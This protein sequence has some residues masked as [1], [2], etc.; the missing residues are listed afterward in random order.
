MQDKTCET[1]LSLNMRV[2]YA[3]SFHLS[4]SQMDKLKEFGAYDM[5]FVSRCKSFGYIREIVLVP[6]LKEQKG[7]DLPGVVC[8]IRFPIALQHFLRD[9]NIKKALLPKEFF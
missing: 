9:R 6:Q 5:F 4:I 3:S 2:S 7:P 8:R 1:P